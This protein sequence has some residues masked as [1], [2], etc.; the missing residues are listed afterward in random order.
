MPIKPPPPSPDKERA[1]IEWL[2]RY[3]RDFELVRTTYGS[4]LDRAVE[5]LA[6]GAEKE[7]RE[8]NSYEALRARSARAHQIFNEGFFPALNN[9]I[10]NILFLEPTEQ[11]RYMQI[12]TK[13]VL[14]D[15]FLLY[16]YKD[17]MQVAKFEETDFGLEKLYRDNQGGETEEQKSEPSRYVF[18]SRIASTID[19]FI[20]SDGLAEFKSNR[21]HIVIGQAYNV[22][23]S[24]VS[25]IKD[26]RIS[27]PLCD[28]ML[29]PQAISEGGMIRH[30]EVDAAAELVLERLQKLEPR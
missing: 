23:I 25:R 19:A 28:L 9:D 11:G 7:L 4:N 20:Q 8:H 16:K 21:L 1:L 27:I 14:M 3:G 13:M 24:D 12:F 5:L 17:P 22:W 26:A 18:A 29:S 10:R 6:N 30:V 15:Y 2:L